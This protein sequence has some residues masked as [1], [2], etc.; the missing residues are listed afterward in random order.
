MSS[1]VVHVAGGVDCGWQLADLH[2]EALLDFSQDFLVLGCLH[3]CDRETLGSESAC[4]ADSV[5]V[6]VALFGHVEVEHDVDLLDVDTAAENLSRDQDSVFELLESVVDFDSLKLLSR[7][8]RLTFRL[9]SSRCGSLCLGKCFC[10]RSR[11][12]LSHIKLT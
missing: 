12:A 6:F 3:E 5:Q 7:F 8:S 1:S 10:L 2:L 9:G 4:A 11:L